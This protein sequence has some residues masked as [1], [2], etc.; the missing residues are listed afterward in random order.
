M[1]LAAGISHLQPR[2]VGVCGSGLWAQAATASVR[3]WVTD[4]LHGNPNVLIK[5]DLKNAFNSIHRRFCV[6]GVQ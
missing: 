2:Q 3:S 1:K 4:M 5:V 6:A